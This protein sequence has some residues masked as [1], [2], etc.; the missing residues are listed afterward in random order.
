MVKTVANM[1]VSEID[2]QIRTYSVKI[3]ILNYKNREPKLLAVSST[4]LVLSQ[5]WTKNPWNINTSSN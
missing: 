4:K 1:S 3:L 2:N 5:H